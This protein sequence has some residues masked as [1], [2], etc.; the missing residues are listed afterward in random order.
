MNG[1]TI[2]RILLAIV[3]IGG[4]IGIGVTAYNAGVTAGLV[5]SGQV[6]VVPGGYPV[7]PG[8]AYIGYGWGDGYHHGGG[9]FGFLGGLL[10]L[11]LLIG[12]LRAAFGGHRRGWGGPGGPA[13]PRGWGGDSHRDAWQERVKETHD[14]LHREASDR[15]DKPT[16]S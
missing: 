14:A 2:A 5:Q 10:L 1:R 8:A 15:A 7:A 12:L 4:A 16:G 3:L 13:G 11:F 6:V 9:F